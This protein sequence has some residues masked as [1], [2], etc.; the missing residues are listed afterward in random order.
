MK[1][2]RYRTEAFS[3]SKERN[4]AEVMAFETFQL[5]NTD[6]LEH[7]SQHY[8]KDPLLH[9]KCTTFIRE[10]YDNGY[11]DDM[12][13]DEK[14]AFFGEILKEIEHSTGVSIKYA[15]WL[16]DKAVVCDQSWY[17][18]NMTHDEDFEC[19]EVG[20]IIL[21]DLGHDGTL[22]GYTE[23]PVSLEDRFCWL[24]D[25][26]ANILKEREKK[27]LS[28]DKA[29]CLDIRFHEVSAA[30]HDIEEVLIH[31]SEPAK[32]AVISISE[33]D[34]EQMASRT[35][36]RLKTEAKKSFRSLA[37][38]IEFAEDRHRSASSV[39]NPIDRSKDR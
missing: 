18:Y 31:K 2:I 32:T 6:I 7:I 36:E 29:S 14:V 10:L 34:M 11:V 21:S 16:A 27:D 38:Q 1:E 13:T 20:P 35:E 12:G 17:G 3:G 28:P 8:L 39:A 5:G 30:I 25:D 23:L 24:T 22:Y 33:A 26:M 37:S 19:Y 9:S 4:A 15:L